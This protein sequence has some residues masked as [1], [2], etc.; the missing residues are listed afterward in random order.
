VVP[1]ATVRESTQ[2]TPASTSVLPGPTIATRNSAPGPRWSAW[3]PV[4]PP[5]NSS[6]IAAKKDFEDARVSRVTAS[7]MLDGALEARDLALDYAFY[8]HRRD[9]YTYRYV[10]NTYDPYS[11]LYG[12]N[13]NY[14]YRGTVISSPFNSRF[15]WR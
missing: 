14:G 4:L 10:G 13:Y 3:V 1:G 9:P 15:G 6:V 2:N 11:D 12:Y 5:Q 8:L 7:A